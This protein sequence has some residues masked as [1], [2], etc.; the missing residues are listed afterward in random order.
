MKL[1][2]M[3]IVIFITEVTPKKL[4][5]YI[6]QCK[7]KDPEFA[8]C[9]LTAVDKVKPYLLKGI[10]EIRVPPYEPLEIPKLTID[11]NLEALRVK[12]TLNNMKVDGASAFK[13]K[14]LKIDLEKYVAE[15]SIS[16]PRL[17]VTS[18]YDVSGRLLLIPLAGKGTLDGNFSKI[19]FIIVRLQFTQNYQ[20]RGFILL[21][22]CSTF[23]KGTAKIIEKKGVKFL[24]L[25]KFNSKV[26]VGGGR[27]HFVDKDGSNALIAETAAT[28]FNA[29]PRLVLDI[30]NPIVE[31][32]ADVIFTAYINRILGAIPI[33]ELL[34]EE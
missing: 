22:D 4:P 3:F 6:T 32:T 15:V 26:K 17:H 31:D 13:I 7:R 24:Q 9:V 8:K 14:N 29:N 16:L 27:V 20:I 12:A 5:D 33:S 34:P 19:Y 2:L 10:P 30:I 18:D 11:R 1:Y 28:F 25:N 23:A 21:S